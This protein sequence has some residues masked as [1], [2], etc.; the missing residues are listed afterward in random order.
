MKIAIL[1]SRGIPNNY[2]GFERAAEEIAIGM[3]KR[4]HQVTVYNPDDHPYAES[5]WHGVEIKRIFCHESRLKIWGTFLFDFL[6]LRDALRGNYDILLE[7]GYEPSALFFP[8]KNAGAI[9][10]CLITN[11]DGLGWKRSKWNRVLKGFIRFCERR[12][13]RRS[14]ALISDNPGIR[15]YYLESFG[16]ES[17]YIPYGAV[18]FSDPGAEVLEEIGV[19]ENQ[20]YMLVARLEPENN[21]EMILDGYL[22]SGSKLPFIVVGGLSTKYATVLL[23][24]YG[25]TSRI[26]FVGGIYDY[27]KLSSLR[28]YSALYFHGHSVGGTNPSLL[29]AMASN[30]FIVAH[31]N[32]FNRT[33][34]GDDA[35]YFDSST[36]V[37]AVIAN[38]PAGREK[39]SANNRNKIATVYTWENVVNQHI[40]LFESMVGK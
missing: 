40:Q 30:A 15:D 38:P 36:Q 20:Y 25:P 7:L 24:K 26:R 16:V 5:S 29:E 2:G 21:I 9:R 17:T 1:G 28:W 33:I 34:L 39:A 13:V 11:M 27:S 3:V 10:Q 12:A 19:S 8:R 22:A 14:D 35:M 32:A 18:L 37:S 31:D 4:G 6:S 23:S